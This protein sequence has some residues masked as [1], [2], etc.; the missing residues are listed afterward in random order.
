MKT[1]LKHEKPLLTVMLQCPTVDPAIGKIRNAA[2]NGAEAFGFQAEWLYRENQTPE[3]FKKIIGEMGGRPCY[4]TCYR[5]RYNTGVTDEELE[6]EL[7]TLADCGATLVDVMG[8]MYDP[9]PDQMAVDEK[10]IARQM[11]LIDALHQKGKEVL[12]S[13]HILKFTPAER[14]ME[15]AR[16]QKRRGADIVKIVVGADTMEQQIENLRIHDLL[17]RELGAEFLFLSVGKSTIH[18]RLGGMLGNSLILCTYEHDAC[19][20]PQQPL[21]RIAKAIRDDMGF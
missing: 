2:C 11:K 12:M 3:N 13:C 6:E 9:Q 16:E 17:K 14:V 4:A 20:T 5:D 10:A 7:L 19:S 15:I 1:F 21:L 18:R 8:D